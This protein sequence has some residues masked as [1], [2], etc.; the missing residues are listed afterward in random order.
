MNNPVIKYL[1]SVF[2][3]IVANGGNM[4]R[5]GLRRTS[6]STDTELDAGDEL[7]IPLK[8]FLAILRV[9]GWLF[10]MSILVINSFVF[11][12]VANSLCKLANA[13]S[14]IISAEYF[15]PSAPSMSNVAVAS[16]TTN[17]S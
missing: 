16:E 14:C 6:L 7:R 2:F 10:Y 13:V 4:A 11:I 9:G 12:T 5:K 15:C 8:P 3:I 17:V 1:I